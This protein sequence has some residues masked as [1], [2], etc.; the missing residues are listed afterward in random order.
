MKIL[1]LGKNGQVGWELQRALAPLG[2]V[3]AL[4]RQGADGLC[5]D[6]ADLVRL[7][8]TVRALAPD[9]IVNAA[10]YTAVD[11]A[12]SEPDLAMLI[13]GEAPGVL[14]REAAALG[15]WLIHYSTDY[16]FDGS[17]EEQ[18]QESAATGP[19]SVYGRSKLMG[20]Q[21]I[22]ASG[23]KALIL[24]TSWVYAARGHNFAKTMLRLATERDS[25]NVVADQYGA[26]TGAELIADVTAQILYRVRADQNPAALAGIYHLAAAGET[27][28]HGF[29]QFV[30]EHAARNGVALKV[31]P[32]QIGAIPT[33]AYPVPAPRPRNS[34]LALA[35]LETAF[36]LK[37][38]SWQQGAQRM[39]DEIQR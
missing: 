11:K 7:A 1:L 18:W 4:D 16:V 38:P 29:A 26:P 20:E 5:G 19:L 34:R 9:V 8:A 21:A 36:Q 13:N 32:D 3:I 12:E 22:Q 25:L 15:A 23:A 28:W 6:L 10:A 2:E 33:E 31:A 27:S 24:R 14:A 30:L 37:M 17:G 39:L 35:K